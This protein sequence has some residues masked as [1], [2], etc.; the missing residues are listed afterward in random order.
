MWDKVEAV[1]WGDCMIRCVI[2][3]VAVENVELVVANIMR[4]AKRL[5]KLLGA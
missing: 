3:K 5:I 4:L 1:I 2:Q